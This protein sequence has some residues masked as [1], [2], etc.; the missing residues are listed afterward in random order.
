MKIAILFW[1]LNRS[2]EQTYDSINK[3]IFDVLK[4]NKV[5]YDVYMHTYRLD[6]SENSRTVDSNTVNFDSYKLLNPTYFI[7]DNQDEIIKNINLNQYHVGR[8]VWNNNYQTVDFFVL[9]WYSKYIITKK[10]KKNIK[11]GKKYDAV[12]YI[13]PDVKFL[14]SFNFAWL[15]TIRN[16]SNIAI[17]PDFHHWGGYND[18]MLLS[19]TKISIR[20]GFGFKKIIEYTAL[21]K[22]K[23]KYI[24]SE[25]F[26]RFLL[27]KLDVKIMPVF[28]FF[29][30]IRP[31]N[32]IAREDEKFFKKNKKRIKGAG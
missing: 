20:Y 14:Q 17:I 22:I 24:I 29:K 28:F 27:Q 30:R 11:K 13:R 10:L 2:L 23:K 15:S 6:I 21:K 19:N 26:N 5:E 3:K 25:H 12:L 32:T 4:K 16:N 7:W 8:D 18:R 1:G 9:A 31:N